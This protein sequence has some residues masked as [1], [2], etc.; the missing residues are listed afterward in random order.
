L[1]AWKRGYQWPVAARAEAVP[2]PV[3]SRPV[4]V[5]TRMRRFIDAVI[6]AGRGRCSQRTV[7]NL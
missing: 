6:G 3:A 7:K 5:R 4:T 1:I 2:S